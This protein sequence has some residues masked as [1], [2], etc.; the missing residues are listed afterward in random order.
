MTSSAW[1]MNTAGTWSAVTY[2]MTCPITVRAF[3]RLR[4][5]LGRFR[6]VEKEVKR[7]HTGAY[8]CWMVEAQDGSLHRVNF[9]LREPT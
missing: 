7:D 6:V 4:L 3:Y 1:N 2:Q 9:K 8:M 5:S